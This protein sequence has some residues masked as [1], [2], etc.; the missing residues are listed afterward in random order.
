MR[1]LEQDVTAPL[2]M[3]V[4][5]G[6]LPSLAVAAAFA[7]MLQAA[8]VEGR[9]WRQRA[10]HSRA[11][12]RAL[13]RRL[14]RFPYRMARPIGQRTLAQVTGR[15]IS[16]RAAADITAAL[17]RAEADTVVDQPAVTAS[18]EGTTA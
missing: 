3:W 13:E 9:K 18:Q 15:P 2:W 7:E 16:R 5:V 6:L 10:C 8:R 1:F 14:L 12:V 4:L 17:G 11:R